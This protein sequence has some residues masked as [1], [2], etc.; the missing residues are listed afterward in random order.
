MSHL[1][2][3]ISASEKIPWI[4]LQS[5]WRISAKFSSYLSS[6]DLGI[7]VLV[8]CA[9][10]SHTFPAGP[11]A[12]PHSSRGMAVS[13]L[14]FSNCGNCGSIQPC[15]WGK[16]TTLFVSIRV[17]HE[18]LAITILSL[19]DLNCPYRLLIHTSGSPHSPQSHTFAPTKC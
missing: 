9:R 6:S 1:S 11:G 3:S 14:S 19:T 8:L 7:G 2:T 13:V 17:N 10:Y 15:F 4:T 5:P 12:V 18:T 16:E